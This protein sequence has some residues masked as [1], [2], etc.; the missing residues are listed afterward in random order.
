MRKVKNDK[1]G[2]IKMKLKIKYLECDSEQYLWNLHEYGFLTIYKNK[3]MEIKDKDLTQ[4][5]ANYVS[6]SDENKQL[7]KR[8][9]E[10]TNQLEQV[11]EEK[12]EEI[13][14]EY[15]QLKQRF[16]AVQEEND[17]LQNK[18]YN[19]IQKKKD[20]E[21]QVNQLEEQKEK[22]I[23]KNS[24]AEDSKKLFHKY[25]RFISLKKDVH[26]ILYFLKHKDKSIRLI[27][28][29]EHFK[30]DMAEQTL[31]AH[32]KRLLDQG[33]LFRGDHYGEYR[34]NKREL[35][36][37]KSDVDK[38]VRFIVGDDLFHLAVDS[39]NEKNQ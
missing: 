30:H 18:V 12:L 36:D 28:L 29:K 20:F 21:Q 11:D 2:E 10:L 5:L 3:V 7:N 35:S 25:G 14:E 15:D 6:I 13:K 19:C 22:V 16:D 39:W 37:F 9:T 8:L 26:I 31:R 33:L 23:K 24:I 27:E 32:L 1:R 34:L 38:I 17:S 4:T